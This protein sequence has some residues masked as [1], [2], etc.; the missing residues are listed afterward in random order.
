M[1]RALKYIFRTLLGLVLLIVLLAASL[2]LPPVQRW[3]VNRLTAYLEEETGLEVSIG[4]VHLAFPLDIDIGQLKVEN[5]G[6]ESHGGGPADVISVEHALIDLDL[7]RLLTLHVGVEAIEL[8]NGSIHTTELIEALAMDGSLGCLRIVADDIDLRRQK[9]NVAEAAMDG[10]V[11]DVQLREVAEEDTTESAPVDWQID[12]DKVRIQ[13]SKFKVQN[14]LPEDGSEEGAF[15]VEAAIRKA[16]LDAGDINLSQGAYR[17][18]SFSLCA[19]SLTYDVPSDS[20][21]DSKG[22]DVNHLAFYDMELQLDKLSYDQT[23]SALNAQL[24]Q[25]AFCERSGFAVERF[26]VNLA[27]D[28]THLFVK[29]LDLQTPFSSASGEINLNWEGDSPL[30]GDLDGALHVSLGDRDVLCL[31]GA[32]LPDGLADCYPSLPLVFDLFAKGNVDSLDVSTCTLAMPSV[33]SASTSGT[34]FNLTDSTTLGADLKWDIVTNNLSCVNRY[35]ALDAVRF[36]KM[37]LHADIRLRQASQFFVDA[38][39]HEGKGRAHLSADMD[40]QTMA[41]R[42]NARITDLQL[43]DFLPHDSLYLLSANA[44]LSGR[45]TDLLSPRAMVRAQ[46]AIDHFG[47]GSWDLD[48]IR[49]D[50]RL[51]KGKAMLEVSSRNDLL[52]L[53]S[54]ID[55]AIAERKLK[56]ASFS[57]DVS[58]IDLYSLRLAEKPL[59]ASMVMHTEGASDFLQTH[60]LAARIEAMELTTPDS[61]FHPLDLTLDAA[62][63]PERMQVKAYAGDLSFSVFSDQGLDSLL[64]RYDNFSRELQRQADSLCIQHDTLRTL[65][66]HIGVE[67]DCGQKNPIGNILRHAVGYTFRDLSFH[68][69]SSPADGLTGDGH[70]HA[71]NTGGILIDSIYWRIRHEQGG[72]S[73]D[74]RAAN[75]PKNRVVTFQSQLR[76]LLTATGAEASVLFLD[77]KGQK[78]VDFGLALNMLADGM[79][80]HFTP[81]NPTIAYRRFTLNDDNFVSLKRSGHLDALVDLLADDGTGLKLYTTPNDEAQQ[82]ISLSVKRFNMGELSQALPFMP[83][84][85]GFLEGDVHYMQVD[86]SATVSAEMLVQKMKYNGVLLG[87]IGLNGAYFPNADASHYVDGIITKDGEEILLLNGKYQEKDGQGRLDGGTTFQRM[88]FAFLNAFMP[89]GP[90]AMSGYAWGDFTVNGRTDNPILNGELRTDSLHI[91]ADSYNVHLQIPD[92]TITVEDSRLNLNRIEAYAA[93]KTPL[94]LDGNIDFS[95]L[96]RVQMNMNVRASDYQLINSPKRQGSLAY[97]KVF[98]NVGGRLWGTL[99]DLKMRGRL[100]VLGSTDVSCVLTDTPITVDDQLADIVTFC[101]FTDTIAAEPVDA[102]RQNIDIQ[103]NVG[104]AETAQIHCFLSDNGNDYIDLQGGGE[105]TMTYDLQNDM[106]LWGRYTIGKGIMRYSLMAIPLND[107]HIEQGSYVEFQ[108]KMMNPRLSINA[109]ER[110]RSTV[111]ENSVPRNVAFDVGLALSRTLDD[112]GL[113]FTLQAPEDMSV[114]NQLTAMTAEERGRVAVTMLVTGMYVTDNG[115]TNGSFNYANTL[116]SYLQNAINEIAGK[117]LSTVD[118]NFGISNGTTQTGTTTTDYSFSFA[119]RFWGNRISVIVGGKVSTGRDAVNTGQT[120][121][122]NISIEYRLDK[123][124]SR[125]VNLFYDRNY[126]SLLEGQVTKMGGGIVLR[127]KAEKLGELFIFKNTPPKENIGVPKKPQENL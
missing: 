113:E 20:I 42:A 122:D 115:E 84:I 99:S 40:M 97:G 13:N 46:A 112:M 38:L 4:S 71:L 25:F 6:V 98:V 69:V 9:V 30:K 119:K 85:S 94:V 107:F 100:D 23:S 49:A 31:A 109:S 124:A 108:G 26:A 125:Y 117:A 82:D 47:Y 54:C 103:M 121:I 90:F 104:I 66:P 58:H 91:D 48:S 35:L 78:S 59:S 116:N 43:H 8:S 65:L 126:E 118:V 77:G 37:T 123:T 32:Y 22:L 24:R 7:T 27:L 50:C 73:L 81:L 53:Q 57:M 110:V 45:G 70:M 93:G 39:L 5:G 44:K 51:E 127:K 101:D 92:H 105:M 114:Q 86:S 41:Y 83:D 68:L 3:A 111:T 28:S 72:I 29:G 95:D 19:D 10:C 11:L 120:I 16:S 1:K 2:Y 18:N 63:T 17:V 34:L 33:F 36:P 80:V 21:R 67:L 12:V 60:S 55:A 89:D 96:E 75:G 76:A 56:A 64:A 61:V 102:V 52:C 106:Q 79:R 14:S 88:P 74:A 87:N 62:L 15:M